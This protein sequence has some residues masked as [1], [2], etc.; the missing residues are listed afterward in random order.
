MRKFARQPGV[1][2]NTRGTLPLAQENDAHARK[3]LHASTDH[4]HINLH[5]RTYL[6]SAH[7]IDNPTRVNVLSPRAQVHGLA[8]SLH[9]GKGAQREEL[10]QRNK[11]KKNKFYD[12]RA[13]ESQFLLGP[14]S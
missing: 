8:R 9:S 5:V 10:V 4:S 11:K 3:K 2:T 14:T 1:Y 7:A 6:R 12:S 13:F